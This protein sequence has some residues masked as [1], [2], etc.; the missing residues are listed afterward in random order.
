M[1]SYIGYVSHCFPND[2]GLDKPSPKRQATRMALKVAIKCWIW[3]TQSIPWLSI[4]KSMHSFLRTSR[5]KSVYHWVNCGWSPSSC[6]KNFSILTLENPLLP[7]WTWAFPKQDWAIPVLKKICIE[8][9]VSWGTASSRIAYLRA[10]AD[11][12]SGECPSRS[13]SMNGRSF[14]ISPASGTVNLWGLV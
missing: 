5:S 13:R 4:T 7:S 3:M 10:G 9:G 6:W 12:G 14:E 8:P 2:V 11:S 1:V